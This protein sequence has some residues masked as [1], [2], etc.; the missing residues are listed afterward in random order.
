MTST[1]T[2]TTSPERVAHVMRRT[3][4]T[5][6]QEIAELI[7]EEGSTADAVLNLNAAKADDPRLMPRDTWQTQA[8]G[9]SDAEYAI[10][11]ANAESLGW[12]VKTY[13]EWLVS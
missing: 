4:C 5:E 13:D 1:D 7:A 11:T 10:Y 6:R 8:R 2:S 3:G 9:T 12:S